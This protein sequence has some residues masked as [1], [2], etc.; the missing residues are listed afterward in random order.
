L[1]LDCVEALAYAEDN[2]ADGVMASGSQAPG[3]ED[4]IA[5]HNGM[6]R[7]PLRSPTLLE[8]YLGTAP[9]MRAEATSRETQMA[10]EKSDR[11]VVPMNPGNS[12]GGKDP[13][14][15]TR[16][17][18]APSARRG[19]I[20]VDSRLERI[21]ERARKNPQERFTNLFSHLDVELLR[22]SFGDLK[23]DRA[24]GVDGVTKADL[25]P[26]LQS[27]LQD[28][29]GRLHR[30]A[31]RPQPSRRRLIPKSNGKLRALGIPTIEDK[32]V[33]R[34]V[35]KLLERVYEEDFHSFSYGFRP[36]KGCHDALK[37]LSWNIHRGRVS[38]VVEADIQGFFDNVD[39]DHLLRML[40]HRVSDPMMLWLV[41][42][43]L[44]AGA[45]VDG[46]YVD[47]ERGT[48]QG[49]VISPLLGNIFLH[50][51][52]DEWF[53]KAVKPQCR[54]QAQL[55]RYADD[56]VA[57]FE[58]ES[59]ARRFHAD[60]PR[61]LGKFGLALSAE[62]TRL[63]PFG[64][65]AQRDARARGERVAVFDFLGLR[66]R[67]GKSRKG[68]FKVK[69]STSSERFRSK[70]RAM[71]EW[72][73]SN[74]TLPLGELLRV[75]NAKLRGHYAYYAVS[76]N[77]PRLLAFRRTVMWILYKWVNRRSQRRSF[78]PSEWVALIHRVGLA[79]PTRVV[80]NLNALGP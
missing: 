80:A 19:G 34:A 25:L 12:G 46:K 22:S 51:V 5:L 16:L 43:F 64:R 40:A 69:W 63:L 39:H 78:S 11:V 60:L 75:V 37:A 30:R 2:T 67:C 47:T 3:V 27:H 71:K 23:S 56:F 65:F 38:Y 42:Q 35:V 44:R 73:S 62:K 76:D 4:P 45:L 52:L 28:L 24:A 74:R 79:S 61:R 21:T 72:I 20:P 57:T 32:V 41:R 36:G 68:N 58:L 54:G 77:W 17:N 15:T 33:Q 18:R 26:V 29:A 8:L 9:G 7:Q 70:V 55:V 59:D 13:T 10:G 48:P 1:L 66:H 49:G 50:H 14:P 31:Y 53:A 6:T